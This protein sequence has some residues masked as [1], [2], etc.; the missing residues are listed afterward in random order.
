[1]IISSFYSNRS[2]FRCPQN[3][4]IRDQWVFGPIRSITQNTKQRQTILIDSTNGR[5][6]WNAGRIRHHPI[7]IVCFEYRIANV[8]NGKI[9][10]ITYDHTT[11]CQ[12]HRNEMESI[13]RSNTI[14]SNDRRSYIRSRIRCTQRTKRSSRYDSI[15][16]RNEYI[17]EFNYFLL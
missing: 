1:M 10:C 14:Q 2:W 4:R 8:G 13:R 5:N 12:Q 11:E 3:I 9:I 17:I 6:S 16:Y 15:V 7:E